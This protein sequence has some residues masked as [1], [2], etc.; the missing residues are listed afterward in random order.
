MKRPG[1]N[2][3][4]L[5]FLLDLNCLASV[6]IA[7]Q[8]LCMRL[9]LAALLVLAAS[10]AFAACEIARD[11]DWGRETAE[12]AAQAVCF[13]L[14]LSRRSLEEQRRAQIEAEYRLK[15][16]LLELERRMKLQMATLPPLQI[17]SLPPIVPAF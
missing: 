7:V 2:P 16:R 10:P 9:V 12:Q 11:P 5:S 3:G 13:Q 6:V 1:S 14:E 4:P 8:A 15:L 17:P